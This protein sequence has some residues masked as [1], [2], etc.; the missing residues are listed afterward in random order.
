MKSLRGLLAE[1]IAWVQRDPFYAPPGF[2]AS[3]AALGM[4]LWYEAIAFG[5]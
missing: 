1:A 2:A 4:T 3:C 5:I